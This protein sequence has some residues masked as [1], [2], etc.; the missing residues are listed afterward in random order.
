MMAE[1]TLL[2]DLVLAI[3]AGLLGGLV[4]VRLGQPVILGYLVG[5][6]F[7]GPFT[8]GPIGNYA[9]IHVLAEGGVA[10]LMF[11]IGAE[12]S[13]ADLRR[14]GRVATVGGV[15]QILGSIAL[16]AA[17]GPLLGLG[18]GPSLF[19]GSLTALSSTVVA[20]RLLVGRGELA[21]LHGRVAVGYALVQ[22]LSL[23]PMMVIL[24]ALARPTER[25]AADLAW[26]TAM[27]AGLL[28][29]TFFVGARVVPWLLRWVAW[30]G[31]RELFLLAV[32]VLALGTALGTQLFGLSLA[33]GAFLAGIVVSESELS[34]QAVGEI[35]PVR[36]LFATL[37]FVSV[38]MLLDPYFVLRN[39]GPVALVV[40]VV[41]V[42]KI[43]LIVAAV[44]MFG[45]AG[46]LALLVGLTLA[47][48]GEF[49]FVL[50]ELGRSQGLIDEY[51]Y[52][53]TLAGA[54]VTILATPLLLQL[55]PA[56]FGILTRAPLLG[57]H[58]HDPQSAAEAA[59]GPGLAHHT[60]ICGF[61]RV[62][63]EVA[64]A[65]DRRGFDYVVIEYAPPVVEALRVRGVKVLFGDAANPHVL[66]RAGIARAR[67]LAVTVPDLP[68]ADRVV[69]EARRL[70][71]SLDIV[72]RSPS[73]AGPR[74]L[75]QAG[76]DE[77][78]RP[79]LEAGL[80]FVRHTLRRY[81]V[82]V[83]EAQAI[84]GRRRLEY[85]DEARP[86]WESR[87]PVAA[88]PPVEPQPRA[89][90]RPRRLHEPRTQ[91]DARLQPNGGQ[92]PA[93]QRQPDER[94]RPGTST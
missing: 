6:V 79:E 45:Y 74:R 47:Q 54:L 57:R 76:A 23:V 27:A 10:L 68:T 41:V 58:F 71:R 13:I 89:G 25:L 87:P 12:L 69:R 62:G 92:R 22:D 16:G 94:P 11:A 67:V 91:P 82:S 73:G 90:P 33:F 15:I 31:S 51:L 7:I 66:E 39:L 30:T 50:A 80:E 32:V 37:F 78:V 17:V 84:V 14:V 18:P 9:N 81:G 5:G 34:H 8:P 46:R 3:G 61:G 65:L 56:L 36:D 64:A 83:T 52:N 1:L 86:E 77:V 85:Y 19:F 48:I 49:S 35:Q 53:L 26:A 38:G 55:E 28:I 63:Q 70:N 42:G 75:R 44:R 4:A 2:V 29:A 20:I 59:P 60:V 21:S 72:A 88:L 40:G 43:V 24:P 93:G